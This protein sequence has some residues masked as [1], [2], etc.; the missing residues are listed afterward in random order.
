MHTNG[1][2]INGAGDWQIGMPMMR[3]VQGTVLPR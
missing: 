3:R 2:D 1:N